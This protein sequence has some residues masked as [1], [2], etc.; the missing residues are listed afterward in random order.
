MTEQVTPDVDEVVYVENSRGGDVTIVDVPTFTV[1]GTIDV[2]HHPDDLLATPDGSML[3]VNRQDARDL[4]AID[5]KLG[6]IVW[7]VPLSGIPHHLAFSADRR[8]I[9]AAIFNEPV[10]DV[11]DLE[12]RKVIARAPVGFGGHGVFLS[13]DG[14]R[15]YVGSLIHDHLAVVDAKTFKTL[16]T[17]QFPDAVRPFAITPDERRVYVQLSRHHSFLV[18]D[19]ATER[20]VQEVFMPPLPP[21]VPPALEFPH[22]VDHGIVFDPAHERVLALATTGGY[23]AA[24]SLPDHELLTTVPLGKEPGWIVFGPDGSRCYVSNRGDDTLSVL[25]TATLEEIARV[26]VGDYPQRVVAVSAR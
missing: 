10:L 2:G 20:V 3:Y 14:E 22:T 9:F 4:V 26:P 15:V 23:L 7:Q 13:P 18:V 25:D 11:V 12:A 17:I 16:R 1:R 21:D 19:L 24:F 8:L 5:T 6:E